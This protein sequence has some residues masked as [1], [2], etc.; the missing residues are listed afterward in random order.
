MSVTVEFK[1][2]LGG[3]NLTVTVPYDKGDYHILAKHITCSIK[4]RQ[5]AKN[6]IEKILE[7]TEVA[8]N[9]S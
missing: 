4:A 7:P 3:P 6:Y 1:N 8:S 2:V 5:Y 9:V